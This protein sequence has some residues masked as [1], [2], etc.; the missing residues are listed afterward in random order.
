MTPAEENGPERGG[1][2][3]VAAEYVLGVLPAEERRQVSA[4]IDSDQ[5]FARL[6]DTWE[7]RL[8]ALAEGYEPIEP[9]A[10]LKHAIDARLFSGAQ[11][12][13]RAAAPVRA[14]IWQSLT[15]WRG[16]AALAAAA[17]VVAVAVFMMTPPRGATPR[18]QL[19]AAVAPKDSEVQY[20][21]VYNPGT[22][23]LGLS[24]I[25]GERPSGKDFELWVV[26]GQDPAISLGVIPVG[27]KVHIE[28]SDRLRRLIESGNL[29]AISVEP[30]G[31]S[32]TGKATGPIVA[33]GGLS[34][35]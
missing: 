10:A 12:S 22:H 34:A 11:T 29:L 26:K 35:I 3:I 20:V 13:T 1:D 32:P 25:A 8:S 16:L 33:A 5:S 18:E 24:H 15:F 21:A 23:E 27:S 9:P 31:G 19:V 4:R 28:V 7:L 30:P 6:V 2:D 17:F 14:G